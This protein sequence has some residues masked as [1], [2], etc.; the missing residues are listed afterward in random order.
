MWFLFG[1]DRDVDI[2]KNA[3]T[4]AGA[5]VYVDTD[6]DVDIHVDVDVDSF[7]K[8]SYRCGYVSILVADHVQC[9]STE[10]PSRLQARHYSWTPKA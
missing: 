7:F 5:D 4:D 6:A 2:D 10:H 3:N 8:C 1:V 9:E